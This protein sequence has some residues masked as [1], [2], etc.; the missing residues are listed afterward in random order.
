MIFRVANCY[1]N[2]FSI[3]PIQIKI[4]ELIHSNIIQYYDD[5]K[6]K[7]NKSD[8]LS[9]LIELCIPFLSLISLVTNGII[10]FSI[11]NSRCSFA[12]FEVEINDLDSNLPIM[13][14]IQIPF[15][16]LPD[17]ADHADIWNRAL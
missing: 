3:E 8:Q 10:N 15:A 11:S 17:T 12:D 5:D 1:R 2:L 13:D 7:I 9:D 4:Q 6:L 14:M 16:D